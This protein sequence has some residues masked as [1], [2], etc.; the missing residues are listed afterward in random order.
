VSAWFNRAHEKERIAQPYLSGLQPAVR[1]AQ[2]MAR[3]LGA[4][5]LLFRALSPQQEIGR[6]KTGIAWLRSA[7]RL[8]DQPLLTD[9]ARECDA[10]LVA[11]ESSP[12]TR[13]GVHRRAFH[14]QCSADL[15]A[16]LRAKGQRL[17]LMEEDPVV[18]LPN[19]P[20]PW[21]RERSSSTPSPAARNRRRSTGSVS[22]FPGI[23]V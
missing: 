2:E 16:A 8:D 9:A 6:M 13:A 3:L 23:A 7:L 17:Y 10:L 22:R 5:S 15:D 11:V 14:A 20:R 4:G 1:V 12:G 18:L 19:W 21:M